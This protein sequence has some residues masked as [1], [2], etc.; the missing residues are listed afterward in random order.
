MQSTCPQPHYYRANPEIY[1]IIINA[2]IIRNIVPPVIFILNGELGQIGLIDV[3]IFG[4]V[5]VIGKGCFAGC[6]LLTS[7]TI[8]S[9]SI[10]S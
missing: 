6:R 10:L 8:E 2:A 1:K 7:F 9:G 4:S 3:V 5:E